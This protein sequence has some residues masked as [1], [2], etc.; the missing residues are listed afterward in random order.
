MLSRDGW[1]RVLG[2]YADEACTCFSVASQA[3]IS[4]LQ[5]VVGSELTELLFWSKGELLYMYCCTLAESS[6]RV[7]AEK[8]SFL[9]VCCSLCFVPFW[10]YFLLREVSNHN[11]RE[12][13]RRCSHACIMVIVPQKPL[14]C[15]SGNPLPHQGSPPQ[16]KQTAPS[17]CFSVAA[18]AW[19]H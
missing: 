1:W 14:Y 18:Q 5:D 15:L 7:L 16:C 10:L 19:R 4:Q 3:S 11:R 2:L 12:P 6:E 17:L 13:E 9:Q 8:S